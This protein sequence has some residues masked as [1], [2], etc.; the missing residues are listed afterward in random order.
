M[1]VW[2]EQIR[3][4]LFVK[5]WIRAAQNFHISDRPSFSLTVFLR[6]LRV[7]ITA[8][9]CAWRFIF[10]LW[11]ALVISNRVICWIWCQCFV[12]GSPCPL[13]GHISLSGVRKWFYNEAQLG[14]QHAW[15]QGLNI[16]TGVTSPAGSSW[17]SAVWASMKSY[18]GHNK[19]L[20]RYLFHGNLLLVHFGA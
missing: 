1:R 12:Q 8:K 2:W 14:S 6:A 19:S 13:Y 3:G 7:Q 18:H 11:L 5:T 20:R 10:K 17:S 16:W 4:V 15:V 9:A